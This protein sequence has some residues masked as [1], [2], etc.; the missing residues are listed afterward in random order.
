[1]PVEYV[2]AVNKGHMESCG[3]PKNPPPQCCGQPMMLVRCLLVRPAAEVQ[4]SALGARK[5]KVA[6]RGNQS[7]ASQSNAGT[8][9]V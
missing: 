7:T 1:M 4:A 3:A 2:C 9:Q 6:Q 5:P 8:Q